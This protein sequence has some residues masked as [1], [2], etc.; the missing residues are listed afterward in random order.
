[1]LIVLQDLILCFVLL[2]L[3]WVILCYLLYGGCCLLFAIDT[4]GI[5]GFV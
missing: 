1:M 4:F 3:V 2:L 5:L